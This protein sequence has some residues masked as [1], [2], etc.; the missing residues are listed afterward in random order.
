[1]TRL[2]CILI[3]IYNLTFISAWVLLFTN[4]F[5]P[6]KN[7]SEVLFTVINFILLIL[8]LVHAIHLIRFHEA[9]RKKQIKLSLTTAIVR[10]I[11]TIILLASG[12]AQNPSQFITIMLLFI[13]LD[14]ISMLLLRPKGIKQHFKIAEENRELKFREK[15]MKQ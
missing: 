10:T 3:S 2:I 6:L 11:N 9:S 15:L 1:M 4:L 7:I 13:V 5:P 12:S 14:I 8:L